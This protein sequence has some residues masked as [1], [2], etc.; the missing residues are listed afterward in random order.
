M[1][2]FN[3]IMLIYP[4]AVED[5]GSLSILFLDVDLLLCDLM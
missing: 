1:F 2:T 5:S 3:K 4:I